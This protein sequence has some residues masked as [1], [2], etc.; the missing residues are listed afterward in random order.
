VMRNYRYLLIGAQNK[1]QSKTYAQAP[2]VNASKFCNRFAHKADIDTPFF[3]FRLLGQPVTRLC[4]HL[5]SL[6][7]YSS[8]GRNMTSCG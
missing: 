4:C 3:G 2:S 6:L 8:P 7:E 1:G 5:S